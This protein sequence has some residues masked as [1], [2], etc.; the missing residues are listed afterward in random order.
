M[1][2]AGQADVRARM[3]RALNEALSIC[4][5]DGRRRRRDDFIL[6]MGSED[7]AG[8]RLGSGTSDEARI[9]EQKRR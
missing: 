7:V 6:G 5:R 1:Q 3:V 9:R 4:D 2:S 8:G